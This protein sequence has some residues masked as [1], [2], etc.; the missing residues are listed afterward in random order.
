MHESSTATAVPK[1]GGFAALKAK[2]NQ[3][4]RKFGIPPAVPSSHRRPSMLAASSLSTEESFP[5]KEKVKCVVVKTDA[6]APSSPV[7]TG[8]LKWGHSYHVRSPVKTTAPSVHQESAASPILASPKPSLTK[9]S[10]STKNSRAV[11]KK[12]D[13][14]ASEHSLPPLESEDLPSPMAAIKVKSGGKMHRRSSTGGTVP[15]HQCTEGAV[16]RKPMDS[17]DHLHHTKSK[18]KTHAAKGVKDGDASYSS[19]DYFNNSRSYSD[20]PEL[21][22]PVP[23]PTPFV[24]PVVVPPSPPAAPSLPRRKSGGRGVNATGNQKKQAVIYKRQVQKLLDLPVYSHT[25]RDED[26]ILQALYNQENDLFSQLNVG[27]LKQMVSAFESCSAHAGDIIVQQ[28]N[29]SK[30]PQYFYVIDRGIVEFTVDDQHVG[31]AG[32]GESFGELSLL[33]SAPRSATVLA[34]EDVQLYRIDALS[35]RRILSAQTQMCTHKKCRSIESIHFLSHITDEHIITDQLVAYSFRP[36]DTLVRQG[37]LSSRFFIIATGTVHRRT[38]ST[39]RSDQFTMKP[40]DYFG[41]RSLVVPLEISPSTYVAATRGLAFTIHRDTFERHILAKI[42]ASMAA[43]TIAATLNDQ[44]IRRLSMLSFMMQYAE[45]AHVVALASLFKDKT[46]SAGE[47]ILVEKDVIRASLYFIKQ[48][49]VSIS[50]GEMV[51][52]DIPAGGWFG[53]AHMQ[54]AY[55]KGKKSTK[56]VYSVTAK[57]SC[58]C[59]VLTLKDFVSVVAPQYTSS[60]NPMSN[61]AVGCLSQI[62]EVTESGP[63]P[64]IPL[65]EMVSIVPTAA[66]KELHPPPSSHRISPPPPQVVETNQS[67]VAAPPVPAATPKMAEALVRQT[68]ET[69]VA[70]ATSACIG[71]SNH[72]M[73]SHISSKVEGPILEKTAVL[74]L[75]SPKEMV[76]PPLRKPPVKRQRQLSFVKVVP[77]SVRLNQLKKHSILGEGT[78]GI[79]WLVSDPTHKDGEKHYALKKQSKAFLIGENQVEAVIQEKI[80]LENMRHPFLIQLEKTYQD[81]FF[82]YMLLEFVQGGELFSLMHGEEETTRLPEAQAKFYALCLADVLDYLRNRKYVYRDLKG[83]NV[84][85]DAHGYVKLI[86]FGFC[87]YLLADKTYTLCGTPG[88]LSPEMVTVQGHTFSTDHWS[89]G[90]LIYE[91]IAGVSPFYYDSIDQAELFDSIAQDDYPALPATV[92]PKAQDLIAGLLRKDPDVRLG[93]KH[94]CEILEHPWFAELDLDGMR[95]R[96]VPA[97]WVPALDGPLDT[98]NFTDWS[99]LEQAEQDPDNGGD[100]SKKGLVVS[101]RDQKL[102]EGVF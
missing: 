33:Y 26:M 46:Y 19:L 88:Y 69:S 96:E 36:G 49:Q 98:S 11:A 54:K 58:T 89:L 100:V 16:P 76:Q 28:G 80:M 86:D 66:T 77:T 8:L 85:L 40:G 15:G 59:S 91:M 74:V 20:L 68:S 17:T 37:E 25:D 39:G 34:L 64:V 63:D 84:M 72:S 55:G 52:K 38:K 93:A 14:E 41:E 1:P 42:P 31:T 23:T 9:A 67:A 94:Q 5:E 57:T 62:D 2:W 30:E 83:E 95:H 47:Q 82:I 53:E 81:E 35:F 12:P 90:I 92:S 6:A 50:S 70:T 29:Q 43:T 75:S 78:F 45:P 97:P 51:T 99:D 32:A 73:S 56:C 3:S 101:K 21:L 13:E 48:G 79:V 27:Q 44:M 10:A 18:K 60:S 102:F 87:K 7:Q 65:V 71:V 22:I 24:A 4:A 61:E